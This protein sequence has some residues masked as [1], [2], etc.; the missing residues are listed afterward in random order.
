MSNY[1]GRII[2]KAPV[3]ISTTQ[4]SGIWTMQQ[5]LQAIKAGI[6][7]G[8]GTTVSTS[9]TASGTWT[10]PAGVTQV[11]YLVVAGGAGGGGNYGGG[12]GAGGYRTGTALSVTAG[13]EYTVT[14]GGGGAGGA[15]RYREVCHRTAL[16]AGQRIIDGNVSERHIAFI[17]DKNAVV[18]D[19]ANSAVACLGHR[20]DGGERGRVVV[21]HIDR[22]A[23]TWNRRIAT[24]IG[25]DRAGGACVGSLDDEIVEIGRAHV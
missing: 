24:A 1:P 12:G 20:L 16:V 6:W 13:T 11:D 18:E 10:A 19:F 7:P 17:G 15:L 8:I 5:A 3:T 2:T 14:V 22:R 23:R 9:F 25:L 21:R 4:A